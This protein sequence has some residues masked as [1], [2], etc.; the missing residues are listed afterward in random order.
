MN[1][2]RPGLLDRL[3]SEYALGTLRGRA[4]RRFERLLQRSASV[5][6]AVR[7]WEER[8]AG[9]TAFVPAVK[10]RP[11]V[12]EAIERRTQPIRASTKPS[13]WSSLWKPALGFA[14]GVAATIGLVHTMPNVFLTLDD[15]AQ[16]QQALP[17]SYVG[18]LVD[19]DGQPTLLVSSTRH[20]K[21][22]TVK[23]LRGLE[24]PAGKVLQVW[25]LPQDGAPFPLGVAQA[26][27]PPRSTSFEMVDTSEKLLANVPR[28]AVSLEDAPAKPGALPAEFILAGHCVKLW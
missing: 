6:A 2:E 25:A 27:R 8:L 10:P 16:R 9:L 17:Q 22:V 7:G 14:F 20:G 5:R 26:T 23:S 21:R 24:V 4:R 3:A 12:W 19:K 18:L 11:R 1:Y 28:L 13:W 15:I